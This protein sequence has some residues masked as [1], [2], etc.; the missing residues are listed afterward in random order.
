MP[1]SGEVN[2]PLQIQT[3]A[4]PASRQDVKGAKAAKKNHDFHF[5][6]LCDFACSRAKFL[7]FPQVLTPWVPRRGRLRE[8]ASSTTISVL[9]RSEAGRSGRLNGVNR[10]AITLG[11][12]RAR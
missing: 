6:D 3:E 8:M 1:P 9:A 11:K 4:L 12:G 10:T 5:A 2:S 7:M